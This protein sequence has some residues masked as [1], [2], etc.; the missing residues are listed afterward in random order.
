MAPDINNS[1]LAI[2]IAVMNTNLENLV[3]A[4]SNGA[5]KNVTDTIKEENARVV[6]VFE[7]YV[8]HQKQV[9]ANESEDR[10]EMCN[11]IDKIYISNRAMVAVFSFLT[12]GLILQNLG[13]LK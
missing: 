4:L 12:I 11:K 5:F 2:Q 3:K 9:V 10:K 6:K 13:V 7:G 1:D 8:D